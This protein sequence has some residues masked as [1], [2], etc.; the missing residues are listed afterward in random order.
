M[1]KI[2]AIVH[3]HAEGQKLA[4][5][6]ETLRPCDEVLV[7]QYGTD[8][9]SEKVARKFGATV[10]A[11]VPG[12]SPGTYLVDAENDWI[13]CL[14]ANESL[15]QALEASL[16]EWKRAEHE[17]SDAFAVSLRSQN[18]GGQWRS[19]GTHTRLVNRSC[20]NWLSELPHDDDKATCLEGE[21]L[22]LD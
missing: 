13:L 11:A 2:S 5:A 9:E 6:L 4:R 22:R 10:K 3:C 21:L 15:S 14:M 7:I 17:S 18:G 16:L 20:V 19:E 8:E 12:V 1:P